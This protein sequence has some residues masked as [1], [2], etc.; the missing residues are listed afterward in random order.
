MQG[1]P[2]HQVPGR[3]RYV[4]DAPNNATQFDAEHMG[5]PVISVQRFDTINLSLRRGA[6]D[7]DAPT[8][9]T[10]ACSEVVTVC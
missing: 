2:K 9:D 5:Q 4:Y 1:F 8:R 10:P 7:E 6:L 3:I